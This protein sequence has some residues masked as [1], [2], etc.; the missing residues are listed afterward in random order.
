MA[1]HP[2]GIVEHQPNQEHE[3]GEHVEEGNLDLEALVDSWQDDESIDDG[4]DED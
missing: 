3:E 1:D 2:I 4:E